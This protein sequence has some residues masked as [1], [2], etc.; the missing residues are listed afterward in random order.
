MEANKIEAEK[1]LLIA[2]EAGSKG[3]YEKAIRFVEKSL[4][5]Y[6]NEIAESNDLFKKT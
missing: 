1:C 6:P 2:K 5:L 4:K 3:N